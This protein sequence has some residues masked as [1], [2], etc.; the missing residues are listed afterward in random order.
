[1]ILLD[2]N[3]E[4]KF[5]KN[6]YVAL[7]SFDGLHKG[8]LT[9]LKKVNELRDKNNG[10]SMV[11][12]FKNH[13]L[14]IID[15]TKAPKI[16]M[17]NEEKLEILSKNNIDIACLVEFNKKL[18]SLNPEEFIKDIIEKYNVKGIVVGFNYRFGHQNK[19]NIELLK[20]LSEKYSFELHVMN[21]FEENGK[22]VS[23]TLIRNLIKEGSLKE[24][25]ELLTRAYSIK[26]EVVHGKEIGRTIGFPTANLKIS[27]KTLLPKLMVYYSNV[28]IDGKIYKGITSVGNNPTVNGNNITVETYILDFSDFIYDKFIRVY[29]IEEMRTHEKFNSLDELKNQLEKDKNFAKK[30]KIKI[31]L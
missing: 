14:E 18:M 20:E 10:L 31:I 2:E 29:F 3:F 21:A 23:S 26:G 8:H 19:G 24:A 16:I 7:G 12:S 17:D 25:N 1:M 28:E 11:Y 22:V 6:V 9:L 27:E 5:D 15:C 4:G 13:P 30:R